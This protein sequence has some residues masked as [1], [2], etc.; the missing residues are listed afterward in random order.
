MSKEL[1][2][3]LVAAVYREDLEEVKKLVAA[4]AN[5]DAKGFGAYTAIGLAIEKGN[6]DIVKELVKAKKIEKKI[7][8]LY[9]EELIFAIKK[10]DITLAMELLNMGADPNYEDYEHNSGFMLVV[11]FGMTDLLKEMIK[12][13]ANV[14]AKNFNNNTALYV[15][16]QKEREDIVSILL[17]AKADPKIKGQAESHL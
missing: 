14:N 17:E 2:E 6:I 5:V 1:D 7:D 3:K 9:G 4:G 11:E 8:G 13:G 10:K 12:K 15:A 16:A